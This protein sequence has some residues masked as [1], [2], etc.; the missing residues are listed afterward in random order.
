MAQSISQRI[1][2]RFSEMDCQL[3]AQSLPKKRGLNQV[4]IST[5]RMDGE[6][7]LDIRRP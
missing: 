4:Y 2:F 3:Y 1:S 7:S 5:G 6:L